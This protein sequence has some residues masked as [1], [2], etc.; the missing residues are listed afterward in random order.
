[1]VPLRL[2]PPHFGLSEADIRAKLTPKTKAII[3]NTPHNPTGHGGCI[4]L[5]L[6]TLSFRVYDTL[7]FR[8]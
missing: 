4:G 7:G 6:G 3:F 2:E 1:M 5:V 8:V